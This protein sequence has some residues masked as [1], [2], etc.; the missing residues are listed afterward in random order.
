MSKSKKF[1]GTLKGAH[2]T[3]NH[4]AATKAKAAIREHVLAAIGADQARVFDAFAGQGEMHARVWHKA[5]AYVGCDTTWYRDK[6][7]AFVADNRR[8]MRAL[9]L[10][11]FTVFDF[12]AWGSPWDQCVILAAR[13]RVAD[14]EKIGLVLTEGSAL[15]LKMGSFPT[16]LRILAKLRQRTAGASRTHI[17][18]QVIG[19]ALGELCRRLGCTVVKRWEARG[20]TGA[21]MRYI[22]LVLEGK[23]IPASEQADG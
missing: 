9:D 19:R 6:R 12:D 11:A 18:D 2:K 5:A 10:A 14:G 3:N 8:V 1:S 4:P 23:K 22:G 21:A 17:A 15:K 16:S 7:E 13:R 20:K